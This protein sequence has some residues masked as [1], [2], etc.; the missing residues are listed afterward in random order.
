MFIIFVQ[1]LYL[2]IPTPTT[3]TPIPKT[4]GRIFGKK[5][6]ISKYMFTLD[7][8]IIRNKQKHFYVE[9]KYMQTN[10]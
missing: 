8:G 6:L 7:L 9:E 4:R 2:Q 10:C 1:I 5:L 3:Q